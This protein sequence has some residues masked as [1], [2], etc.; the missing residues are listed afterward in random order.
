[1][2]QEECK[3]W[4]SELLAKCNNDYCDAT[5]KLCDKMHRAF[6]TPLEKIEKVACAIDK[7]KIEQIISH[8]SKE[9][10]YRYVHSLSNINN[11]TCWILTKKIQ[12]IKSDLFIKLCNQKYIHIG[13]DSG[14]WNLITYNIDT[15]EDT[16]VCWSDGRM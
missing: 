11:V 4:C 8:L 5:Q 6:S 10:K 2:F 15:L 7:S 9:C 3:R 14:C 16:I 1:M 12:R 13:S